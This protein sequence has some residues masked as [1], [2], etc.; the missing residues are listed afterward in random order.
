M[1]K[2][3]KTAFILLQT[4]RSSWSVG[5]IEKEEEYIENRDYT[6]ETSKGDPQWLL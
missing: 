3:S 6:E 1:D 2:I 5:A 4:W